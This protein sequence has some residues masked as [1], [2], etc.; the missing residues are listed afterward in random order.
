[1]IQD[2]H[3]R[4]LKLEFSV[5]SISES[6]KERKMSRRFWESQFLQ[7][8]MANAAITSTIVGVALKIVGIIK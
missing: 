5:N 1:M 8:I 6:L 2:T 7:G 3:D 4:V